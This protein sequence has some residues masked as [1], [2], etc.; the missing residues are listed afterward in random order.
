MSFLAKLEID[1]EEYNV[2]D[3]N[4]SLFQNTDQSGKPSSEPQGGTFTITVE[5]TSS[6]NFF[7]WM[8]ANSETKDGKVTFYRRDAMSKLREM[9]FDKGYCIGYSEAFHASTSV[10]MHIQL[11]VSAKKISMNDADFQRNWPTMI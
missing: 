2:L 11:T 6:V 10:P 5:S 8:I 7:K 9:K 4:I 3:F 1:G